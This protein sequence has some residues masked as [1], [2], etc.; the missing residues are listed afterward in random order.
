MRTN[1]IPRLQSTPLSLS[2][3]FHSLPFRPWRPPKFDSIFLLSEESRNYFLP[4]P[5]SLTGLLH[6]LPPNDSTF[7]RLC[8]LIRRKEERDICSCLSDFE[9]RKEFRNATQIE[10]CKR[11]PGSCP[12]RRARNGP[13]Q[14]PPQPARKTFFSRCNNA[15]LRPTNDPTR[16]TTALQN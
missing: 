12:L 11:P 14:P 2:F 10:H 5:L 6:L 9:G 8:H 4:S 16:P 3:S 15:L 13:P 7:V 1:E